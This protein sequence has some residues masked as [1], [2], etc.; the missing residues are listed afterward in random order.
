MIPPPPLPRDALDNERVRKRLLYI[1]AAMMLMLILLLLL[2]IWLFARPG[3]GGQSGG[4][5][6]GQISSGVLGSG[7]GTSPA[8]SK[9]SPSSLGDSG[10]STAGDNVQ[11]RPQAKAP[12][13]GP[14]ST[15]NA[16]DATPGDSANGTE[17]SLTIYTPTDK[18]KPV[19]PS[20]VTNNVAPSGG[21]GA[22]QGTNA[23]LSG[24][25]NPFIGA[26][27]H[28]KSVVYVVDASDSM[29]QNSRQQLIN[30]SLTEAIKNLKPDQKFKVFFFADGHVTDNISRGLLLAI[31]N[32]KDKVINWIEN[33][34]TYGGTQPLS[35]I[36]AALETSP[37]AYLRHV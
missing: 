31:K 20:N 26:G 4:G 3:G 2:M 34:E 17:D 1:A 29:L 12:D 13:P 30:H 25:S 19:T 7:G 11:V 8:L 14:N 23:N 18:S 15:G 9:I 5:G 37:R 35:G 6:G 32:N 27:P 33:I 36:L 10:D 22:G 24:G 28:P 16:P 21:A